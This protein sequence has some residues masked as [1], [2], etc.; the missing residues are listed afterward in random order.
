MLD[1]LS[2]G[3]KAQNGSY[4]VHRGDLQWWLFYTETPSELWQSRIRLWMEADQLIG[5]TLLSLEEDAFDVYTIPALRGSVQ[6]SEMLTAAMEEISG[7]DEINNIWIAEDDEARIQWFENNGFKKADEHTIRFTRS[8]SGPLAGPQLPEGF[9]L[10]ASRGDEADARLRAVTSHAA[11]KSGMPFE[12][13]WLRT[14]RFV[15]SPVYLK[16]H[17]IFVMAPNGD[18]SAYCIIWTDE[19]TRLGHFEPVGTHPDYQR[20][21][22]GKSL[23]FEGLRRLASEGMTEA[24]V[25][26]NHDNEA[27]IRFYESVGFQKNKRLLT[28]KKKRTT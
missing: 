12:K 14:L 1:L 10:R 21:G 22:L 27:A 16:E 17:E 9:T 6:E 4:Y 8:L 23:L 18:V 25:C 26:T 19:L 5:W 11:F 20:K 2:E 28:Y 13:Y 7:L 15:Q 3:C 24:D